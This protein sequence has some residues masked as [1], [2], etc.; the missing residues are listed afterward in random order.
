MASFDAALSFVLDNEG[1]FQAN[2]N[3]SGNYD[4]DGSL[5][6]TNFGITVKVA[7]EYGWFGA[8]PDLPM[9]VAKA[10]YR[11]NYWDS[12][13]NDLR[14]NAVAGKILDF[15]VNF[16]VAGGTLLAQQAAN[17]FGAGI[18]EDGRFGPLTRNAI[19]D[20]DPTMYLQ[21]LIMAGRDRYQAIAAHDPEKAGFLSGWLARV[22]K[23]PAENPATSAALLFVLIGA[24]AVLLRGR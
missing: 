5:Q 12:A 8:M 10:I 21:A 24:A 6:G 16:G 14:S 13:M 7:R 11:D 23:I 3:D 17:T 15:R 22:V 2:P 19:D 4:T 20:I 1:G 9:D 18:A